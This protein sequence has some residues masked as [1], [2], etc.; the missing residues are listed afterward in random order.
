MLGSRIKWN[1]GI[2]LYMTWKI[3]ENF[4]FFYR[5][6]VF[7]HKK[8]NS[9]WSYDIEN[10]VIESYMLF[11][12]D[13][14]LIDIFFLLY[15]FTYFSIRR[16][17]HCLIWQQKTFYNICVTLDVFFFFQKGYIITKPNDTIPL[18]IPYPFILKN[19][20]NVYIQ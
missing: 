6:L 17:K 20:F 12:C 11:V 4:S 10:K 1:K 16:I 5:F 3:I 19:S 15:L 7:Q 13:R 9:I 18:Y 14:L 2:I 8:E